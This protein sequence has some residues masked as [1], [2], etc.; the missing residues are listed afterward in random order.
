MVFAIQ[1]LHYL[2]TD[3]RNTCDFLFLFFLRHTK[4]TRRAWTENGWIFILRFVVVALWPR[5][6][7]YAERGH[8]PCVPAADLQGH[9]GA[10]EQRHPP[11]RPQAPEH[12]AVLSARPPLQ[13]QQHLPQDWWESDRERDV[14]FTSRLPCDR[15]N[16]HGHLKSKCFIVTCSS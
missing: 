8:H 1:V 3:N 11:P 6:P 12:P 4:A 14:S 10:A 15:R 2:F 9:A 5:S 16:V 13:P 7:P